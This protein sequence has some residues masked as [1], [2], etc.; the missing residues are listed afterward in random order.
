MRPRYVYGLRVDE[1]LAELRSG[2]GRGPKAKAGAHTI[3]ATAR[4][5]WNDTV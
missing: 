4:S 3:A 2:P 1:P 5:E